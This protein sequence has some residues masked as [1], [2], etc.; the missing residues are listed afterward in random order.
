MA[1]NLF[2]IPK[3]EKKLTKAGALLKGLR[4]REALTQKEFAKKGN[5]TVFLLLNKT[6]KK[7]G[8]DIEAMKFNTAISSLMILVNAFYDL[9]A[10]EAG[11][12]RVISKDQIKNL[13]ILVSPFACIQQ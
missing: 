3:L 1:V 13:L 5:E 7:V 10:D 11:K 2:L 4:A 9:P 12:P 6:V 8:D